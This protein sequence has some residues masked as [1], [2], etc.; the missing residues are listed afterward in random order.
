MSEY[1]QCYCPNPLALPPKQT[2]QTNNKQK[3]RQMTKDRQLIAK[4]MTDLGS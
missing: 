4:P 3:Q 2:K 1:I